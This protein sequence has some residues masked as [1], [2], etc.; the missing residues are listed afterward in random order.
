MATSSTEYGGSRSGSICEK[1]SVPVISGWHIHADVAIRRKRWSRSRSPATRRGW[2]CLSNLRPVQMMARVMDVSRCGFHAWHRRAPSGHAV[3]DTALTGRIAKIHSASKETYGAPRIHAALAEDGIGVGR[4]R[5][6][7]L[8]KAAALASVSRCKGTR[9]TIRDDRVRPARDLVDRNFQA[10]GPNQLW[11]ADI[12]Y[13]PTWAGFTYLSPRHRARTDGATMARYSMPS[14][15]GSSAGP[16][17]RTSRP[18]SSS[19]R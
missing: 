14:P 7:R 17:G 15:G 10:A 2:P 18:S 11:G 4:K 19:T 9:T 5:D 16:W 12:T 8:M 3:A 1:P 6:E 13:A